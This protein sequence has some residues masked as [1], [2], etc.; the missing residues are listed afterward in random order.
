MLWAT[1][2]LLFWASFCHASSL[3]VYIG[4]ATDPF[5]SGDSSSSGLKPSHITTGGLAEYFN[6]SSWGATTVYRYSYNTSI[7]NTAYRVTCF[8]PNSSQGKCT[9]N[10]PS[11]S[12]LQNYLANFHTLF[13]SYPDSRYV[14]IQCSR[15][16]RQIFINGTYDSS[17]KKVNIKNTNSD[18]STSSS[19][20]STKNDAEPVCWSNLM[21][22]SAILAS[23]LLL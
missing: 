11:S 6:S 2:L 13:S 7:N 9:C 23:T 1:F 20:S 12:S 5:K 19:G 17:D 4:G 21:L 22:V 15:T 10:E 16:Y 14:I 8:C 18:S 3:E